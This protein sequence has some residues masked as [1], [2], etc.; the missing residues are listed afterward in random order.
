MPPCRDSDCDDGAIMT[1]AITGYHSQVMTNRL[2]K[3]PRFLMMPTKQPASPRLFEYGALKQRTANVG[4]WS[5]LYAFKK[6]EPIGQ[7]CS[8]LYRTKAGIALHL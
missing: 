4:I 2:S 3:A 8:V 5:N 7:K 1:P 6:Q